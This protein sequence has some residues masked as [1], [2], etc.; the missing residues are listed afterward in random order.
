VIDMVAVR[1]GAGVDVEAAVA[2]W[3]TA[4]IARRGGRPM[5]AEHQLRVRRHLERPDAFLLVAE[6]AGQVVG[7]AVG[8]QGRADDGAGP[9]LPG[10]C[11]IAM[12]FVAPDRWGTGI[13]GLLLDELLGQA[14]SRGYEWAQLWT[15][16]DNPRAQRLYE[17]HGF[18]RTGR[19]QLD[20]LG[21]A[22]VHYRRPLRTEPPG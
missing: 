14:R 9:P 10:L 18:R 6:D 16:A 1:A 22:I 17:G 12:V 5:P 20:D 13:G 21:E 11:H 15:H 7:M 19:E 4:N 3:R 2:V 8:M